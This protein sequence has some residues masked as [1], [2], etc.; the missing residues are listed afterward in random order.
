MRVAF[1]A[2]ALELPALA[3]RGIGRYV[4][5]L[6]D[7]LRE[8][9]VELAVLAGL[10]RPPAPARL[11]ELWEHVLLARDVRAEHADLLHSPT[12]DFASRRPVVAY[13]VTVHDL[14]PL[15][16]PERYLRSGMKHRLRYAAVR[17]ATRV[18]VPSRAVAD[19]CVR[20]LGLPPDRIAVVAEAAA[21]VFHPQPGARAQVARLNL[22]E[23]YLLWVGGLDPPDPRKGVERLAAEVARGDGPPLVLAGRAGPGAERLAVSG[24]V[25]LTGRLADEELAALYSA[26][27]ALVF[28]SEDEGF[29]LPPVEA[30][31][32][33]TPVA[34]F[35]TGA[36]AETLA[37]MP[38][39]RLVPVGDYD[40]LLAAAAELAGTRA[41]P[42]ARTWRDVARETIGVYEDALGRASTWTP[43]GSPT[44]ST[45]SKPA[46]R[47]IAR[48][49]EREN[50][51]HQGS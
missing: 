31:A 15:R 39:A 25:H 47:S 48:S 10:T 1:D 36:L 21:P 20:L 33:G 34:A 28:P 24:R 5:C 6:L 51:H 23:R 13:V 32:C 50:P 12:I 17:R 38:A 14:A 2:R 26:A 22:P 3:E 43:N 37:G 41:E 46:A 18:I 40:A 27:D 49:D 35:A 30:L 19:D 8:E 42:P 16:H 9:P 7:A 45:G 4:R 29:G 11:A 44:S